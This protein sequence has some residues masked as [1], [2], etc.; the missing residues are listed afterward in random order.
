MALGTNPIITSQ[1]INNQTGTPAETPTG[2]QYLPST[3][4]S[5]TLDYI[6]AKNNAYIGSGLNGAAASASEFVSSA[7]NIASNAA[8][9]VISSANAA[10]SAA[11]NEITSGINSA[12]NAITGSLTNAASDLTSNLGNIASNTV[13]NLANTAVGAVNDIANQLE[14][15]AQ[16]YASAIQGV[17]A[18]AGA[19]VN[20]LSEPGKLISKEA[21]VL[22]VSIQNKVSG[23]I[24]GSLGTLRSAGMTTLRG[25]NFEDNIQ[26]VPTAQGDWRIRIVAPLGFGSI[27]FPVIPTFSVGHTANY[28][29]VPL[30]HSNYPFNAYQNSQP[31]DIQ[32]SCEWPVETIADGKEWIDAVLL[33]RTLTKMFY[34]ESRELGQPPLICTL[35]GLSPSGVGK[36]LPHTPVIVKAFQVDFRDDVS[37]MLC[38]SDYVPRLS[39][40]SITVTPTY[41]RTAQRAF[42]IDNFRNGRGNI[43]I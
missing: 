17:V 19:V 10:V 15:T 32:I 26:L 4:S 23:I 21:D 31:N 1:N 7:A 13:G 42:N 34:G 11:T 25:R 2:Q 29:A 6:T 35:H 27:I 18:E 9:N 3:P 40:F 37:Y 12:A 28:Q 41:S 33:G 39:T 36:V 5:S 8:N 22:A 24:S 38:G 16:Q 43:R 30:L 14:Q 20:A